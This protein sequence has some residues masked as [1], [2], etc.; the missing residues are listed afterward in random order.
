MTASAPSSA[1]ASASRRMDGRSS[2]S[3]HA[4]AASP[5]VSSS[6]ASG[7]LSS[8]SVRKMNGRWNATTAAAASPGHGPAISAAS[9]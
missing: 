2:R 5:A 3:A 7:S 8:F 9:A 6:A 4:I 1:P